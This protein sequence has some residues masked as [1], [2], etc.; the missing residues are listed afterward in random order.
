MTVFKEQTYIFA[1]FRT[2]RPVRN[3]F[4]L[5]IT[6]VHPSLNELSGLPKNIYDNNLDKLSSCVESF[7]AEKQNRLEKVLH[8]V[9]HLLQLLYIL[10]VATQ[11]FK[12]TVSSIII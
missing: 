7:E 3:G 2:C 9:F 11:T 8:V 5:T 4:L 1:Q 12:S 10:K 6:K